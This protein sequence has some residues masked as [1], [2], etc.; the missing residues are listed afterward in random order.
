MASRVPASGVT[1]VRENRA[2]ARLRLRLVCEDF[3]LPV[4]Q[5]RS[6]QNGY[7][8]GRRCLAIRRYP[9]A[10]HC[11]VSNVEGAKRDHQSQAGPQDNC[12]PHFRSGHSTA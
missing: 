5:G 4:L 2:G 11:V 7:R 6:I 10:Q 12:A 3:G 8:I 1:Q 9:M